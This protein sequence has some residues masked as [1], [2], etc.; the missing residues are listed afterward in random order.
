MSPADP[1]AKLNGLLTT[2]RKQ[3]PD[4]ANGAAGPCQAFVDHQESTLCEFVRSFFLWECTCA[5]AA[6]AIKKLAA[7]IVDFNELRI[8]MPDEL[9]RLMG[10]TYPRAEERAQ[11]LRAAL[12]DLYA[13]QHAVTL[14]HLAK[15][16]KREAK[17]F[18]DSLEGVPRFVSTRVFL[19]A[20]SGHAAPVDGRIARRL[21][22]AGVL[23]DDCTPEDAAGTLEKRVRAGEML[24]AYAL[25]QAWADDGPAASAASEQRPPKPKAKPA[26]AADKKKARK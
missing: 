20:L 9:V 4:A 15:L 17:D 25:L 24:E 13:R 26:K 19:L 6:A 21:I 8:C 3:Y 18:L 5:R 14:E 2:L 11:R 1:T 7:A 12:T 10:R 23:E 22:D 16:S